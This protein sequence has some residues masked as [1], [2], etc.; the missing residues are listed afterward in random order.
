MLG[1]AGSWKM[2]GAVLGTVRCW[3][4][5]K[6]LGDAGRCWELCWELGDAGSSEPSNGCQRSS[7]TAGQGWAM[8]HG[9]GKC[10]TSE[11]GLAKLLEPRKQHSCGLDTGRGLGVPSA[12]S[13]KGRSCPAEPSLHLSPRG[14][15]AK[16]GLSLRQCHAPRASFLSAGCRGERRESILV[17]GH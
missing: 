16:R 17:S 6:M 15:M 3:L 4:S 14:S 12:A 8:L 5:W 11:K 10:K 13:P 1:D 9:P 2:L 7:S